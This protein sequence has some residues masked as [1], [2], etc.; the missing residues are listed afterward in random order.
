MSANANIIA[1]R[2][3]AS[4]AGSAGPTA[5]DR[6]TDAVLR[7]FNTWAF[8][9]AQPSDPVLLAQ[10]VANRLWHK[11]PISFALY[12]GK[13]PRARVAEPEFTCLDYL[14]S[15]GARIAKVH[16]P[17]AQFNLC[18]TDTH[19]RLN[20]HS[21]ESIDWYFDAVAEAAEARGMSSQ[22]L[23]DLTKGVE[24]VRDGDTHADRQMLESLE[25]C[26][27]RWY[28]GGGH[29]AD[30]ART[31]LEM[32][33]LESRAVEER[34]RGSIFITFNGS[35]YRDLFPATMPV[36]FMYSLRRGNA[37]KPWFMNENC[38]PYANADAL[39]GTGA[40]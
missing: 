19:A 26:A 12:W 18:L 30:G 29:V 14:A 23:S 6:Q 34:F 28:R 8:K 33:R 35:V 32:N 3:T 4:D 15:M 25:R 5:F 16:Q 7:S 21:E 20:G 1:D 10:T 39:A 22:R 27:A 9:R 36:F 40:A 2:A 11:K 31:Y 24:P 38:M 37:V 17:G 13:G